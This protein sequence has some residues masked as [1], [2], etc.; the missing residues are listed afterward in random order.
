VGGTAEE[1]TP[2]YHFV[3]AHGFDEGSGHRPQLKQ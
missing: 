1:P 3:V 2:V